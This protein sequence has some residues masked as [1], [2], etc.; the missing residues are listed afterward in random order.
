MQGEICNRSIFI[1]TD[2]NIMLMFDTHDLQQEIFVTSTPN[3]NQTTPTVR[4]WLSA[5]RPGLHQAFIL[6]WQRQIEF[7]I[8]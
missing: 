8:V 7:I 1:Q 4:F 2:P 5:C 6:T 3:V